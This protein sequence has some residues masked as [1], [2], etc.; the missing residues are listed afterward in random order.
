[1]QE[2]FYMMVASMLELSDSLEKRL[3]RIEQALGLETEGS[4]IEDIQQIKNS[5]N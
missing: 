4:F 3:A 2:K 5:K 1:M